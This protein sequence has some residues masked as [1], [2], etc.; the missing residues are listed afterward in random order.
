MWGVFAVIVVASLVIDLVS[1]GHG[2][3]TSRGV[4]IVWS[5]VWVTVA[6][7]FAVWVGFA[8]GRDKAED[9]L[10]A[11]LMEKSLSVDNLFVFLLVFGRLHM[12]PGDQHRVLFWGVLGALVFRALFIAAGSAALTRWHEVTYVL[13]AIL[14]YTGWR[15]IRSHNAPK[16]DEDTRMMRVL[17][18]RGVA[19][20]FVLALLTIELTDIMFAVDSVPAVFAITSDP[21]IVYTSNVF[22][23]LGLRALY[24]VLAD[25]LGRL[26]YL[27]YA[28][29]AILVLAGTKM[30]ISGW[31]AVPHLASLVALAVIL[32]VAIIASLRADRRDV[33]N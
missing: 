21:F 33:L 2:R 18:A 10:T 24:L 12:S 7:G 30:L 15:T 4:A 31:I 27:P 5:V 6:L 3:A 20:P 16:R 8:L 19:S 23:I 14:I 29:A 13:G 1:H 32:A 9:F 26:R 25:L 11:Y 28:L 17:R 22:A